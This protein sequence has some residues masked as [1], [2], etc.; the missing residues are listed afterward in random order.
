VPL[1]T[2]CFRAEL[3]TLFEIDPPR[4]AAVLIEVL[5]EEFDGVLGCDCFT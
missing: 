5:G 1:W 4:S 2:W 3:C